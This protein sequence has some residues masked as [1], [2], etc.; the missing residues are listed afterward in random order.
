VAHCIDVT[1][2]L[3]MG[4][5]NCCWQRIFNQRQIIFRCADL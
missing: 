3:L 2:L 4:S 5:L 1:A